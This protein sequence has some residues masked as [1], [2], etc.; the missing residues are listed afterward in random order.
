MKREQQITGG[1]QSKLSTKRR[2]HKGHNVDTLVTIYWEIF[3]QV[4]IGFG[5]SEFLLAFQTLYQVSEITQKLILIGSFFM[6]GVENILIY[7]KTCFRL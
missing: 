1:S 6:Y 7:T 3:V 2:G 4:N 5:L